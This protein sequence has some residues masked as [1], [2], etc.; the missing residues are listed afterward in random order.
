MSD[1]IVMRIHQ[2]YTYSVVLFV[3]ATKDLSQK[4]FSMEENS[5]YSLK[6]TSTLYM[7]QEGQQAQLQVHH[8]TGAQF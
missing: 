2:S 4:L 1:N 3:T 7:H 6:M 8:G 5:S